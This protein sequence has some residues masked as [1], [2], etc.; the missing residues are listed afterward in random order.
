MTAAFGI[1]EIVDENMANAARVH[2]VEN[3]VRCRR[4][5]LV[6]F[7]GAAPLHAGRLADKLG[8]EKVIIP[9]NA[10]VGSAIGFLHAPVAFEIVRGHYIRLERF[11]PA[12]VKALFAEM[13]AEATAIAFRPRGKRPTHRGALAYLR[14]VGQGHEV[15]L[16]LPDAR[17]LGSRAFRARVRGGVPGAVRPGDPGRPS[18]C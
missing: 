9:A 16:S 13:S 2:A 8:I 5:T 11:D 12:A 7:G 18:R 10:G 14:Y 3:G 6:A 15:P 4:R 17:S 1:S